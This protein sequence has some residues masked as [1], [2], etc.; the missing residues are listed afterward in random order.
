MRIDDV[1]VLH[2]NNLSTFAPAPQREFHGKL[3]AVQ[4]QGFETDFFCI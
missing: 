2:N 3:F 4:Y 1:L